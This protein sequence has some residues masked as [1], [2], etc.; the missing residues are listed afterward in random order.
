MCSEEWG[1]HD[2]HNCLF[3]FH[4]ALSVLSCNSF[5]SAR[6]SANSKCNCCILVGT[7]RRPLHP[8]SVDLDFPNLCLLFCRWVREPIMVSIHVT[9]AQRSVVMVKS[10]CLN[11]FRNSLVISWKLVKLLALWCGRYPIHTVESYSMYLCLH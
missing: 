2:T 9:L 5:S 10:S 6:V 3:I 1:I 4:E 7:Q 8:L 11:V